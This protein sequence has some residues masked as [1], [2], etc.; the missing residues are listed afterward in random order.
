MDEGLPSVSIIAFFVILLIDI[1][2]HGFNV[3]L[4]PIRKRLRKKAM[5]KRTKQALES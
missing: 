5:R 2:V 3:A 1:F 4:M